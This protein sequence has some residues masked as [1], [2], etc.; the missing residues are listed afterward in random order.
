MKEFIEYLITGIVNLPEKVVIEESTD[1]DL[2]VFNIIVDPQ[3]MGIVI[4]KG[5]KTIRALRNM[6]KAKAIKDNI[7]IKV[8][9]EETDENYIENA[10][11][12]EIVQETDENDQI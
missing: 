3:D 2:F 5:G 6:A 12:K 10:Q 9:L 11:E 7:H 4:G 1:G 8:I